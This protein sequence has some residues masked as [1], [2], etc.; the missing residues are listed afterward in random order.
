VSKHAARTGAGAVT[1]LHAGRVDVAHE[2]F[3]LASDW[4]VKGSGWKSHGVLV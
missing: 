2:V 3:V 1:F 4:A